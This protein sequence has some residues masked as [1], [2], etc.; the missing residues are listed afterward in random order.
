MTIDS[1]KCFILVAES[2]SFARAAEAMCKSQPAVT[3]QINSLEAVM[4]EYK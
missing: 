2:L 3:K 1:L 4:L